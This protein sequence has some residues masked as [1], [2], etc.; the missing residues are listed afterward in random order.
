MLPH[1]HLIQLQNN[2][3][4]KP[5]CPFCTPKSEFFTDIIVCETHW[6]EMILNK[7]LKKVKN[8]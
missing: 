5:I 7:K 8:A 6:K 4:Y 2:E 3:I 1:F